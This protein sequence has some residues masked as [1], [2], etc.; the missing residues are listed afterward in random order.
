MWIEQFSKH[1]KNRF[2]GGRAGNS[3]K[4]PG[5]LRII[6]ERGLTKKQDERLGDGRQEGSILPPRLAFHPHQDAR[7]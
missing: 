2:R 6:N 4:K 3:G 5:G 7:D 1:Q